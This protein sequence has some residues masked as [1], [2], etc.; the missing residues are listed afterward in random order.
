[1]EIKTPKSER[2]MWIIINFI[3]LILL[4]LIFELIKSGFLTQ[5]HIFFEIVPISILIFTYIQQFVSTELWKFTHKSLQKLDER[6]MQLSNKA[7][8]FSYSFFTILSLGLIYIY[9]LLGMRIH[10]VFIASLLY[11]AHI[12]P[13]YFISW[14]EKTTTNEE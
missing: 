4:V 9:S 11:L 12:L 6:E 13:A 2:R 14:T 5:K 10:V 1:M 8:R 7:L 3:S